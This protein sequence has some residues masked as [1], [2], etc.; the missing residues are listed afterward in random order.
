MIECADGEVRAQPV[1]PTW[2]AVMEY[3]VKT[4]VGHPSTP[5]GGT[6]EYRNGPWYKTL[7]GKRQGDKEGKLGP[8]STLGA[9]TG[10][11]GSGVADL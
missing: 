7:R 4:A 2:G 10:A 3:A 8:W 5:K 6:L 11:A 1:V 9:R